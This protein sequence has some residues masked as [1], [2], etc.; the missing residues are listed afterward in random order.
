MLSLFGGEFPS[1]VVVYR[2]GVTSYA[3]ITQQIYGNYSRQPV[4]PTT[5][6]LFD[7]CLAIIFDH[8]ICLVDDCGSSRR[9]TS[10]S[11]F[12][13]ASLRVTSYTSLLCYVDH[14]SSRDF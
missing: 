13:I 3:A 11:S 5:P 2:A 7:S 1:S 12:C 8:V 14:Q 6:R 10:F 9:T 4:V